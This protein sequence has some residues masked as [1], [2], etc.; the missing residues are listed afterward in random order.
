MSTAIRG[1]VCPEPF[2]GGQGS[3]WAPGPTHSKLRHLSLIAS[4]KIVNAAL[5]V[6][7]VY[8][9]MSLFGGVTPYSV[10][11]YTAPAL[12]APVFTLHTANELIVLEIH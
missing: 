9:M 7:G 2:I 11:R 5:D 10:H 6:T 4:R 12:T 3:A 1:P 8:S